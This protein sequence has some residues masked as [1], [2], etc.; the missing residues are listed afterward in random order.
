MRYFFNIYDGYSGLDVEG[1]DFPDWASAR[2]AAV[3]MAGEILKEEYDR[4][5][6]CRDWRMEV[7]D[8]TGLVII[9]L[10]FCATEASAVAS[11]ARLSP[12]ATAPSSQSV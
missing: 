11:P 4:I 8:D 9:R 3:K 10:D 7:T 12:S 6:E 5:L 2:I 1:T